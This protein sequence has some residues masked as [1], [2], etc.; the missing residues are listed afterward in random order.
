M[1]RLFFIL[2]FSLC[3]NVIAQDSTQVREISDSCIFAQ[4]TTQS[5]YNSVTCIDNK[6]R[7]YMGCPME[8]FSITIY[9][10]WGD[11]LFFTNNI[12][13][14]WNANNIVDGVYIWH[15][16]GEMIEDGQSIAVEKIGHVLVLK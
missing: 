10:R 8:H 12:E 11:Q 7:V 3:F 15:V 2:L 5:T 16:K 6:F 1:M 13:Q 14:F 4:N 9:D